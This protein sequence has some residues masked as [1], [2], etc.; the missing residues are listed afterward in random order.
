MKIITKKPKWQDIDRES[1]F[2]IDYAT[3]EQQDEITSLVMQ[4]ALIDESLMGTT[5]KSEMSK[6]LN[7]FSDDKKTKAL[8]LNVKLGRLALRYQVK[9]WKGITNG[10]NKSIKIK[11]VPWVN[12]DG[13]ERGTQIEEE[14]FNSLT[15][16]LNWWDLIHIYNC[17]YQVTGNTEADK[18]K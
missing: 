8:L 4:I 6:K 16:G 7:A 2:F 17:I 15:Q 3:M 18:K 10:N 12:P 9:N 11:L 1:Q 5:Q 14:L 13:E